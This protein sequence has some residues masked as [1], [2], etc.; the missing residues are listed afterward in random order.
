MSDV[1]YIF[2]H[3]L[4][5]PRYHD[6]GRIKESDDAQTADVTKC[7]LTLYDGG[8]TR[9]A[10]LLRRDHADKFAKPCGRCFPEDS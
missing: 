9:Y 10:A 2:A 4:P 7:G 6:Y 5:E 1:V 3:W 8:R